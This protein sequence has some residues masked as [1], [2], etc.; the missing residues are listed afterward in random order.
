MDIS[1]GDI[2]FLPFGTLYVYKPDGQGGL[3]IKPTFS[4]GR[5]EYVGKEIFTPSGMAY[6]FWVLESLPD[7][8][9]LVRQEIIFLTQEQIA[10]L[11]S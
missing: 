1:E 2:L 10:T 11:K 6:S 3:L 4:R 8:H 9:R 7:D 5:V